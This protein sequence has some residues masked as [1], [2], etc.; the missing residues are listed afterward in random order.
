MSEDKVPDLTSFE[1][2]GDVKKV[3]R[4]PT[5]KVHMIAWGEEYKSWP[6][7]RR[8]EFAEKLASSMNHAADLLQQERNELLKIARAQ[9]E[10]LK[11]NSKSFAGQG[12][13]IHK[14]LAA[15]DAEKQTL[16]QEIVDLKQQIKNLQA[17][18]AGLKRELHR[19]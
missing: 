1:G 9:D 13:L 3:E 15:A 7:E 8:L 5:K 6:V 11:A 19:S 4:V 12:Q 18:A 16:Y 17:E 2:Q 14:E 10:Q